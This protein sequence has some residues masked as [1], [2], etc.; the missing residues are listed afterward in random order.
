[1]EPSRRRLP[2]TRNSKTAR[3]NHI[4]DLDLYVTVGFFEDGTPGEVFIKL[5]KEG[6]TLRGL[7]DTVGVLLSLALQHGISWDCLGSRLSGINFEPFN[8]NKQSICTAVSET[9]TKL[10][11]DRP[12]NR[13]NQ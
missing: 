11:D 7:L 8:E 9:V 2:A 3:V 1:M 13:T 12:P 5:G 10:L 6:S 4:G